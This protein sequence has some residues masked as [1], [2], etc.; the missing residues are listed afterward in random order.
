M[1]MTLQQMSRMAILGIFALLSGVGEVRAE[2]TRLE[3]TVKDRRFEPAE[4]QVPANQPITLVIKNAD[5]T[6]MEIE[7]VSLRIEKV[8]PANSQGAV[9]IRAL[10]PGRY[11]FYDDFNQGNR[12]ALVVQ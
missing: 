6:P 7:S 2:D 5:A 3:I 8:I 4:L 11:E 10:K 1:A 9:R 12:G